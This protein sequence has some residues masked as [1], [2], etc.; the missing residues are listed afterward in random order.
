MKKKS[1]SLILVAILSVVFYGY[2]RTHQVL[3]EGRLF[4][5]SFLITVGLAAVL[6]IVIKPLRHGIHSMLF[7][8]LSKWM[9]IF[10]SFA[11]L[12]WIFFLTLGLFVIIQ[13]INCSFDSSV[14]KTHTVLVI[15][16]FLASGENSSTPTIEFTSWRNSPSEFLKI[17]FKEYDMVV[18]RKT[19]LAIMTKK[20]ALG[21]EWITFWYFQG[22]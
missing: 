17:S 15:N 6:S 11:L 3:D 19:H 18:P 13:F 4:Y 7:S 14:E 16:K 1:F 12:I 21:F 8:F 9:R 22:E 10:A 5:I 2:Y 20:G